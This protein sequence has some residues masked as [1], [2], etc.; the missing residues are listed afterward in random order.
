MSNAPSQASLEMIIGVHKRAIHM[1]KEA[2]KVQ[3]KDEGKSNTKKAKRIKSKAVKFCE[4]QSREEFRRKK[5]EFQI[6]QERTDIK[7][8]DIVP[9]LRDPTQDNI[10]QDK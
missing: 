6:Y 2:A 5:G 1:K 9:V 10:K 4:N 7:G 3:I 8:E